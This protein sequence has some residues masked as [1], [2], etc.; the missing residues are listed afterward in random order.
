MANTNSAKVHMRRCGKAGKPKNKF[1]KWVYIGDGL[2]RN[3]G[4]KKCL[5]IT[6]HNHVVMHSCTVKKNNKLVVS[7]W[8]PKPR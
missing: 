4:A 3:E 2:Y 6:S 5:A 7:G 1:Q 8:S